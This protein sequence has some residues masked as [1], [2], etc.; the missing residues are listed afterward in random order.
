[1]TGANAASHPRLL[2]DVG[3][4]HARFAWVESAGAGFSRHASFDCDDHDGLQQVIA[5]YLDEQRLAAPPAAAIGI[6]TPVTGDRV[7]MTNRDWSFS[8]DAVTK[9]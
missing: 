1:M 7:S 9:A 6:A 2:G 4:T 3:G 8:I 5:R